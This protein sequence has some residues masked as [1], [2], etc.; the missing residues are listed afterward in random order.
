MALFKPGNKV[1]FHSI[2]KVEP[3]AELKLHTWDLRSFYISGSEMNL[4][5][6]TSYHLLRKNELGDESGLNL[7]C[8]INPVLRVLFLCYFTRLHICKHSLSSVNYATVILI[9]MKHSAL[10]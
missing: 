3:A 2:A 10:R 9:K 8:V 6:K 5:F 1:K 4:E 7:Y